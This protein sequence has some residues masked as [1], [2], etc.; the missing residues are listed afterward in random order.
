MKKST[1]DVPTGPVGRIVQFAD[2]ALEA[3]VRSDV[4]RP[5]ER[6]LLVGAK[7]CRLVHVL[8]HCG[9]EEYEMGESRVRPSYRVRQIILNH[10]IQ[11][12]SL[13]LAM[14]LSLFCN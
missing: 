7:H 5:V 3:P 4:L 10:K 11:Q 9:K 14:A 12:P 8:V 1:I 6:S 13:S 2:G